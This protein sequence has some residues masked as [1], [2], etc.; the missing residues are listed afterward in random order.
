MGAA[1]PGWYPD[2]SD[3]GKRRYWDGHAWDD[4]IPAPVKPPGQESTAQYNIRGT[5]HVA[6]L[7]LDLSV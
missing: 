2:P 6:K 7:R 3:G 1:S 5:G 4:A